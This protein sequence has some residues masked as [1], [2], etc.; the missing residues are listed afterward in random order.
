MGHY[1]PRT[2]QI[3]IVPTAPWFD[4]E[5]ANLRKE[6][7]K[8]EKRYKRTKLSSDRA[9]FLSLRKQTTSLAL[10][11]QKEF[12]VKKIAECKGNKAMF[13]CVN[14]LLDKKKEAV[15]PERTSDQE[16]ANNFSKYFKEKISKIRKSF[17]EQNSTWRKV[18]APFSGTCLTEFEPTT[19]DEITG[20]ILKYGIKCA[21]HD[22]IPANVLKTTYSVFIP[23]W[24]DLVNLSLSSG[25]VE[26][27]KDG[28]LLP[29]IKELD[30]IMDCETYK[31]YRPLTNLE[32][33]A[34]LIEQVAKIRKDAHFERNNFGLVNQYGYKSKHSTGIQSIQQSSH[35]L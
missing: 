11:K 17:P 23:I 4:S 16:L 21:P 6:R 15:L 27:L 3:K 33:V 26:C 10:K 7:R 25:S 2:K 32:F 14:Q 20:L 24:T 34:K 31:N 18:G 19:E 13:T 5:Y 35:S 30:D 12:Y 9:A 28:V 1:P 8:A 29:A 22:P